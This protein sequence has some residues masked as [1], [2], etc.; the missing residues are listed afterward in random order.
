MKG[1]TRRVTVMLTPSDYKLLCQM[2]ERAEL[3]LSSFV[4]SM[5]ET[6]RKI[7]IELGRQV[8]EAAAARERAL[9]SVAN[10]LDTPANESDSPESS[11]GS[12]IR[13][14]A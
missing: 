12:G 9:I 13:G 4:R 2:A 7:E 10:Q 14:V 11:N 3:S 1:R 5:I 6:H 8:A